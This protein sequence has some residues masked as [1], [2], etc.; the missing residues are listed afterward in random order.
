[1]SV[2]RSN[3]EF[4]ISR[5][6]SIKRERDFQQTNDRSIEFPGLPVSVYS[7]NLSRTI[8]KPVVN[9]LRVVLKGWQLGIS[10]R[11]VVVYTNKYGRPG[12]LIV[13]TPHMKNLKT[14]QIILCQDFSGSI[15]RIQYNFNFSLLLFYSSTDPYYVHLV[16]NYSRVG[17]LEKPT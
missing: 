9:C 1:M 6:F 2:Y 17:F 4:S 8:L 3:V 15:F 13:E 10:H 5:I 11:L 14:C 7:S 12:K 16:Y